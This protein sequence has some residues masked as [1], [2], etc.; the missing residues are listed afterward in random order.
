MKHSGKSVSVNGA[1]A[2]L[3]I[4]LIG[5]TACSDRDR[6]NPFDPRN[7]DYGEMEWLNALAGNEKVYLYWGSQDYTD[8]AGFDIIR[9]SLADQDTA[10]LNIT[11]LAAHEVDFLDSTAENSIT[12]AYNLRLLLTDSDERPMTKPD[13]ATPGRIFGWLVTGDG[14]NVAYMTPDFR[15]QIYSLDADFMHAD[16]LQLTPDQEEVWVLDKTYDNISRFS[17]YGESLE[18]NPVFSNTA[19]FTFNYQDR[20]LWI[21]V[22]GSEGVLY[23]FGANGI[24]AESF[25]TGARATSLAVN[26]PENGVWVGSS[27]KR[28]LR[29]GN[30]EVSQLEHSDFSHP[31]V[32]AAGR[33]STI[34]WILDTEARILFHTTNQNQVFRLADYTDPTDIAVSDDGSICWVADPTANIL[35]EIDLQANSVGRLENL[36][37]PWRLTYSRYDNTVYVSGDAGKISKVGPGATLIWQVD[38]PNY[39]GKIALEFRN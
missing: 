4:L 18:G 7:P 29:V 5:A 17:L 23:H 22:S 34:A 14:G 12:Y 28:V 30:G 6:A 16:D 8:L 3:I 13:L 26:Y 21:A 10:V 11:T 24:L 31:E 32:V 20:S 27:D 25:R 33:H 37:E 35:Y 1:A 15:D 19:A 9:V 38:Y 36:G 2:L 39:P